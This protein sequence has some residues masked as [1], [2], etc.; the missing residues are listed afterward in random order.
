MSAGEN[1]ET[2]SQYIREKAMEGV[3]ALLNIF[4]HISTGIETTKESMIESQERIQ[5]SKD[6]NSPKLLRVEKTMTTGN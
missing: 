5:L 2:K 6:T 1:I 4:D 3:D